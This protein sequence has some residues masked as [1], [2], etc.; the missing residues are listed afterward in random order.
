MD[1]LAIDVGGVIIRSGLGDTSGTSFFSDNYL[2]TPMVPMAIASIR[3]LVRERFG[4]QVWIVS[5]AG[6]KTAERTVEW[7]EHHHLEE[8]TGISPDRWHFVES[9]EAKA[10]VCE[11]FGIT[12]FIDDNMDVMVHLNSVAHLYLFGKL[13]VVIPPDHVIDRLERVFDWDGVIEALLDLS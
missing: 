11:E 8:E 6:R 2:A 12:T 1:R 13:K 3:R 4:D 7:F 9:H 10:P 5:K